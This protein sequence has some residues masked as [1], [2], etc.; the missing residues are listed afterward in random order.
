[1]TRGQP[2]HHVG[3]NG[4][5]TL[6]TREFCAACGSGIL[7]YGAHA[8]ENVY[9]FYGS[10]DEP[11]ALPPKGEF[12]CKDRA[13]WMPEISGESADAGV[14]CGWGILMRCCHLACR[15]VSETRDQG[16]RRLLYQGIVM[17]LIARR[18]MCRE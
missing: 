2:T 10:L 6:L 5:G 14:E 18:T 1:M 12:F 15:F 3:D 8:G 9:V 13:E 4:S 17:I 16:L 7:E 11:D